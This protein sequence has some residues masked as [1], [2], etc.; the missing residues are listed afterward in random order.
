MKISVVVKPNS[1]KESV[2]AAANGSL[3]VRVKAPPIEGQANTRVIE[4][5]SLHFGKPK[6][7]F[8]LL[9]GTAGKKKIFKIS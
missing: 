9:H 7:S 4:L 6:S 1:K 8:E 2:T 5:L 3:V